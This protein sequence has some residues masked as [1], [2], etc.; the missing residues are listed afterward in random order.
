MQ[1][2]RNAAISVVCLAA[3][4]LAAA[5]N[6]ADFVSVDTTVSSRGVA[7]PVSFVY[8]VGVQD[9]AYPLV[10]MAHGHGGTRNEAGAFVSIA[11]GLAARG[12]A[13]IRMDFPG[14]GD[15]AEPFTENNLGNMLQDIQASRGFAIAQERIDKDRVGLL[16]F[17]MGGHLALL[18]ASP[19]EGYKVI[20]TWAPAIAAGVDSAVELL[21]GPAAYAELRSRAVAEGSTPFTTSWGQ[22]QQLGLRWFT[23]LEE[24]R[25]LQSIRQF[26]GPLL[27][28]Y[29]ELDEV[30]SPRLSE[31]VIAAATGSVEVVRYVVEGA[32]H[33]LGLYSEAPHLTAEAVD[34]TVEFL[35]RQLQ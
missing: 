11:A 10:V 1:V 25:P 3:W 7:V 35:S 24:S 17:S 32:G 18:L 9:E 13:S 4:Q 27:V 28:L 12:I 19:D 33:G 26:R 5:A 14:C 6:T 8:P 31:A 34:V 15:S 29:G 16:G 2:L 23:D 22:R 21:G 30:V 20:A